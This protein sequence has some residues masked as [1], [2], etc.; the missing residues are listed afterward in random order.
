MTRYRKTLG[1]LPTTLLL[2]LFVTLPAQPGGVGTLGAQQAPASAQN[3]SQHTSSTPS[4]QAVPTAAKLLHEVAGHF[5]T[6]H[7][8]QFALA[9]HMIPQ[10]LHL[11]G[12][13]EGEGSVVWPDQLV[14]RGTIQR[15]SALTLP[16]VMV[17]CGPQQYI[18]LGDSVFQKITGFPDVGRLLFSSDTSF[19]A[20]ILTG[21]EQASAP[22][23]ATLDKVA[24]WR[25]TGL[26]PN[27]V[28]TTLPGHAKAPPA[29][30]LK[31]ELW[32]GQ[33]DLQIRQMTLTGPMFEGDSAKTSRTLTFSRVNQQLTLAVPRGHLPCGGA[34]TKKGT[35]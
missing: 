24:V 21:L 35:P 9:T 6:I 25:L 15:T 23:A 19:V 10:G 28:L 4:R 17:M 34:S 2:T 8:L 3:H 14:F 7:T 26:V 18:E 32:I 30:P 11:S 22:R 20:G 12:V 5:T 1:I 27:R 31:A 33:Q 16:F 29:A 13:A